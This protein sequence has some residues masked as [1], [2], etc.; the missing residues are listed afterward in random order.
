MGTKKITFTQLKPFYAL[1]FSRES[2]RITR[3]PAQFAPIREI[4]G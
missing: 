3:T 2:A 1:F 4:R